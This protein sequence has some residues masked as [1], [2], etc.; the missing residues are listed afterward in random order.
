M[1]LGT[2]HYTK[3][4]YVM[5]GHVICHVLME[6]EEKWHYKKVTS[7]LFIKSLWELRD[8]FIL[9]SVFTLL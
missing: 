2:K 5:L 4:N 1:S 6:I 3:Q 7:F 8:N 9:H